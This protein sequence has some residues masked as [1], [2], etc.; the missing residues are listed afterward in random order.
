MIVGSGGFEREDLTRRQ[1]GDGKKR[2]FGRGGGGCGVGGSVGRSLR[3]LMMMIGRGGTSGALLACMLQGRLWCLDKCQERRPNDY[4]LLM[5][6]KV[7][8]NPRIHVLSGKRGGH[9]KENAAKI[10]TKSLHGNRGC[11]YASVL[12][13]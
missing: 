4:F 9:G 10:L 5:E 12:H 13:S 6:A 7:T 2:H 8:M 11:S 1:M 3:R